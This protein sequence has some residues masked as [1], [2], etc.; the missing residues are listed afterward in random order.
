VRLIFV[1]AVPALVMLSQAKHL[2][3]EWN[4][5]LLACVAEILRW[6]SEPA[7]SVAEGMTARIVQTPQNVVEQCTPRD[8]FYG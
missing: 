3:N 4:W 8:V 2:G 7:L 5:S 1:G 6:R